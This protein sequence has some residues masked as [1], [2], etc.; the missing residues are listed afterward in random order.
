LQMMRET[1]GSVRPGTSKKTAWEK[2]AS[3]AEV[4]RAYNVSAEELL[5]LSRVALLGS[6]NT[7]KDFLFMLSVIRRG[8]RR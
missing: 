5:S 7:R 4:L 6:A 8:R 1:E 3:D 2:F